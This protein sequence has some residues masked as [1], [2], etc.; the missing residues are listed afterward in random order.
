MEAEANDPRPLFETGDSMLL[1]SG[2]F[3]A[4]YVSKFGI[5]VWH[6]DISESGIAIVIGTIGACSA[7]ALRNRRALYA[8]EFQRLVLLCIAWMFLL[9][10]VVF[11]YLFADD[12]QSIEPMKLLARVVPSPPTTISV[13]SACTRSSTVAA[14]SPATTTSRSR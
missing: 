11:L 9:E 8:P 5:L 13:L 10:V 12:F 6:G 1:Y 2:L 3:C 4:G 7:F 14:R